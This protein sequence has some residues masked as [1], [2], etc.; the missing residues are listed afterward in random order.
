MTIYVI[1]TA[2]L[3]ENNFYLRK[4]Q[5][6]KG[7]TSLL[8]RISNK[9]KVIIV[10]NNGKRETFLDHF[11]V[12]VVYTNNN[13][14][15]PNKGFNELLDVHRVIQLYDIKDS[16]FVIK[17]TGRYF[18]DSICPFFD[19]VDK[20]IYDCVIRYVCDFHAVTGLIGMRCKYMKQIEYPK[21]ITISVEINY[22]KVTLDIQNKQSLDILG[23]HYM[24]YNSYASR[25]H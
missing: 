25:L 22:G 10:E 17:M 9:Y 8:K 5:Y 14:V 20:E 16:D 2:S 18:L 21:D 13:G 6:I 19:I 1:V 4:N 3:I 7:I 23:I 11:G 24:D 15:N 12:D